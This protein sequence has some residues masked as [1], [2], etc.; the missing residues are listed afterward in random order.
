LDR[1]AEEVFAELQKGCM[2]FLTGQVA[3]AFARVPVILSK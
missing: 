1:R 3:A 2:H